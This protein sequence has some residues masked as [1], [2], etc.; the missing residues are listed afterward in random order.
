VKS[1]LH[2]PRMSPEEVEDV[3]LGFDM[4]TKEAKRFTKESKKKV[5][6]TLGWKET[7]QIIER[8]ELETNS[9]Q[10]QSQQ[11]ELKEL[12]HKVLGALLIDVNDEVRG[13]EVEETFE[14]KEKTMRALLYLE[15]EMT[16]RDREDELALNK[17]DSYSQ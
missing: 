10:L 15:K 4:M 7:Q 3:T 13:K 17:S 6:K 9:I 5:N 8:L 11:E 1:G 14:Y 16:E 2:K 12:D